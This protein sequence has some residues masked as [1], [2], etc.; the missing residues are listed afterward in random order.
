MKSNELQEPTDIRSR[1]DHDKFC[2][3]PGDKVFDRLTCSSSS[4]AHFVKSWDDLPQDQFMADGGK[5]RYR[6]HANYTI[7]ADGELARN[8]HRPHFQSDGF[9]RLNGGIERWFAPMTSAIADGAV[10]RSFIAVAGSIFG[11]DRANCWLIEAHQFRIVATST[12]GKPTP[13]G[14]HRDGVDF[15]LISLIGRD[16]ILGGITRVETTT[17]RYTIELLKPCDS[18]LLVDRDVKHDVSTIHLEDRRRQGHRDALVL[19]FAKQPS[20]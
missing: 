19:T 18:L 1:L 5:Y 13:E 20:V 11:L 9:N 4:W 6:R 15:V 16:N 8:D 3:I 14:L 17:E 2:F 10:M 12:A 7:S